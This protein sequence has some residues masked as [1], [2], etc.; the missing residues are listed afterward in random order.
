MVKVRWGRLIPRGGWR[1]EE[2]A[3]EGVVTSAWSIGCSLLTKTNLV[4]GDMIWIESLRGTVTWTENRFRAEGNLC[5][6][7]FTEPTQTPAAEAF[8]RLR[9]AAQSP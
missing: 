7:R 2:G 8:P 4:A 6:I 5:E 9:A 1:P 3:R